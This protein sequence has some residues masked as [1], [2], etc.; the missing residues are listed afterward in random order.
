MQD[1]W[2]RYIGD[3]ERLHALMRKYLTDILNRDTSRLDVSHLQILC[4]LALTISVL[5]DKKALFI[6]KIQS[7][8]DIDQNHLMTAIQQVGSRYLWCYIVTLM[9]CRSWPN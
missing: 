6:Q 7:L 1:L 9:N 3:L 8:S 2:Q 4:R 5:S